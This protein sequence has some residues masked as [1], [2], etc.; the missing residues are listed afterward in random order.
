MAITVLLAEDND[1]VRKIIARLLNGDREIQLIAE[2]TDVPQTIQLI[3]DLQPDIVV[4]DLHLG[5]NPV[6]SFNAE[7]HLPNGRLLAISL[8]VGP[9]AV[10]IADNI[11]AVILLDKSELY[12]ELVPAIKL[13]AS[14]ARD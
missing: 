9:E 13:Y 8:W 5:H 6:T 2:A 10:A 12:T 11:G 3:K 7:S 1:P 4:M 14:R